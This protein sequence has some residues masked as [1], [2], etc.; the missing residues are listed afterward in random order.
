MTYQKINKIKL[1]MSYPIRLILLPFMII[2]YF[3]TNREDKNDREYFWKTFSY[4]IKP[5]PKD[6]PKRNEKNT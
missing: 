3:I 4:F 6:L 2:C 5:I 1:I